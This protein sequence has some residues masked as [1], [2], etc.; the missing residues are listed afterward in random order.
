MDSELPQR[1]E[2]LEKEER[3]IKGELKKYVIRYM[4]SIQ[5]LLTDEYD[6]RIRKII[7]KRD[8]NGN[9]PLHYAVS[10]WPQKVVKDMLKLGAD[11]SIDNK[12]QRIPL[13]ML[14]KN[15]I[16]EFLDDYCMSS[17]GFDALDDDEY[18]Y[19]SNDDEKGNEDDDR[20]YKEL[21]DD[22]DPKFMTNIVQSPITFKYDLLSPMPYTKRDLEINDSTPFEMSVL[23]AICKSKEHRE[24]V[25]H[26]VITS[27]VWLKWKLVNKCYNRNMRMDILLVYCLTWY[28]YYRFGGLEWNNKCEMESTYLASNNIN[29]TTFCQ[30]HKEDYLNLTKKKSMES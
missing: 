16:N 15:T 4:K 14:P 7:N 22:Y 17:D 5:E 9:T 23:N 21:L 12:A 1:K 2:E 6:E 10:N 11:L 8:K 30:V 19:G 29:F 26:P 28:I 27:F 20:F 25:T 3:H 18:Y 24:L 13:E